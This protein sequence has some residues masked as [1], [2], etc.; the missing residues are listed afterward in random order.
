MILDGNLWG[1]CVTWLG[2][3]EL[4]Q[5]ALVSRGWLRRMD[6][7]VESV[8]YGRALAAAL[9]REATDSIL[10]HHE[11][12]ACNAQ[13]NRPA[14][15]AAVVRHI[16]KV[17]AEYAESSQPEA[18]WSVANFLALLYRVSACIRSWGLRAF[19]F[20]WCARMEHRGGSV[21]RF[22][23]VGPR[24][25][26]L[27]LLRSDT[28][29]LALAEQDREATSSMQI[30]VCAARVCPSGD[31]PLD[32]LNVWR[33]AG[34]RGVYQP[35]ERNLWVVLLGAGNFEA[36]LLTYKC[37]SVVGQTDFAYPV[38]RRR[39]RLARSAAPDGAGG[40][41][42]ARRAAP[43]GVP[44]GRAAPLVEG[45]AG[46]GLVIDPDVVRGGA[47]A[48]AAAVVAAAPPDQDDQDYENG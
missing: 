15:R 19:A 3:R 29:M 14:Q 24:A 4:K 35:E 28:R 25:E 48:A 17:Y 36:Q 42:A 31:S 20:E 34:S 32:Y 45:V 16:E 12:C 23:Q 18:D 47:E 27:A 38:R 21:W 33:R 1:L 30:A 10:R 7:C 39:A 26:F 9:K 13:N 5:C 41:H 43:V 46:V 8:A 40:L 11:N 2:P 44:P 37:V 6:G 22:R